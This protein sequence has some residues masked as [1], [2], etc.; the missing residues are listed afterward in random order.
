MFVSGITN[1]S[2]PTRSFWFNPV[3]VLLDELLA[4]AAIALPSEVNDI[5]S[6]LRIASHIM[7]GFF[8]AGLVLN[9]LLMMAAPI[10]L[11]SRWWSLPF[12]IFSFIAVILVLVASALGTAMSFVFQYA[13]NAQP[14]L[15]VRA[16]VGLKMLAF[17]WIA[18]GFTI[19]A[20]IIHIGLCCCCASRRDIK[21]GRRGGKKNKNPE[22]GNENEK[23]A[24]A[25]PAAD[26]PNFNRVDRTVPPS[27]Q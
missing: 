14:D 9:A 8:L 27:E 25:A 24:A 19:I 16:V 20:F 4:G 5:L 7:F 21:T 12:S 17:M 6:I 15:N 3:E 11:Y 2:T 22:A 10:V 23:T 13:M 18:T 1:C 26:L